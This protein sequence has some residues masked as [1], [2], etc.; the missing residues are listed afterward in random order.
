MTPRRNDVTLLNHRHLAICAAAVLSYVAAYTLVH[1]WVGLPGALAALPALVCGW[2]LGRWPG[3]AA[4]AGIALL[5]VGLITVFGDGWERVVQ[6]WLGLALL[7]VLGGVAGWFREIYNRARNQALELE[8]VRSELSRLNAELEARVQERT[9]ALS[10]ANRQLT[11]ANKTLET[12]I[13]SSPIAILVTDL[14]GIIQRVN[15]SFVEMA[16]W[17]EAELLGHPVTELVL[18][19]LRRDFADINRVVRAGDVLRDFETR[20]VTRNGRAV[21]VSLSI[22]PIRTAGGAPSGYITLLSDITARRQAEDEIRRL[23]AELEQRVAERTEA[24]TAA[25]AELEA[26]DNMVAHDLRAPLTVVQNYTD[27]LQMQYRG[28]ALDEEA[29]LILENMQE[30]QHRMRLLIQDLFEFSRAKEAELRREQVDVSALAQA[31]VDD[32]R[33]ID[34]DRRP[35]VVIAA[36]VS[37]YGDAR[38][39]RL[40]LNNLLG[41]A[42]KYTVQAAEPRI[43][44][45]QAVN[46]GRRAIWVRDNGVGFDM[47]QAGRLFEPFQRLNHDFPGTGL[48]LAICHRVI[49]R[50][51]GR[52]WAESQPGQGTTVYFSLPDR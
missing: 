11:D 44:L 46:G 31:A 7:P 19:E 50:H 15:P 8:R 10:Q 5:T 38:F 49:G 41:N 30:A 14:Q 33:R 35:E 45:G 48:G 34:P 9:Q 24:L 51:G 36:G 25:N 6:T 42:W 40:V 32:L 17:P 43:E 21:E 20:R 2:L 39:L 12:L 4:S 18:P 26:Y 37:A 29:Q 3:A 27:V 47:S 22:S 52:I 28:R 1:R 13:A 23:N 16:G